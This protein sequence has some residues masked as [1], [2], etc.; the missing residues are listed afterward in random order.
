M[1]RIPLILFSGGLDSTYLVYEALNTSR[2]DLL[3]TAGP[4]GPYKEEAELLA[5][6][7]ILKEIDKYSAFRVRDS[8]KAP[9]MDPSRC[10]E[11][12]LRQPIAWIYS[13]LMTVDPRK[14]SEVQIGYI[15]GDQASSVH[16]EITAAWDNLNKI[17]KL[18]SV[19]LKM[20]LLRRT[21]IMIYSSLPESV[22]PLLWHCELPVKKGRSKKW[23]AC[24][25]CEACM[26]AANTRRAFDSLYDVSDV[27]YVK[28]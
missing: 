8:I 2:V 26:I 13:A 14:H 5:Q 10:V 19:P 3:Y 17:A 22:R 9:P 11:P 12:F 18:E 28:D 4:Q 24:G 25:K 23:Q 16:H 20:P 1:D 21:K 6:S 27:V 7:K 15:L